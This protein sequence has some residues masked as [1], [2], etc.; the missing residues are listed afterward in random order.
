MNLIFLVCLKGDAVEGFVLGGFSDKL[1]ACS[2]MFLKSYIVSYTFEILC[3]P[4][5]WWD[6]GARII[7]ILKS[8]LKKSNANP[9]SA[10]FRLLSISVSKELQGKGTARELVL[11]FERAIPR[12]VN[13]YGL[14]AHANNYRAIGFYQKM[15]FVK[16]KEVKDSI[17][18]IK[19]IK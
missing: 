10:R 12:H 5:T 7:N 1:N 16:E 3:R 18:M 4:T 15:G 13:I 6:T 9:S 19:H 17:Y 11:A 8:R 2:G 14:S